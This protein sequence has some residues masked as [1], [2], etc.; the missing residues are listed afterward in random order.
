MFIAGVLAFSLIVPL[1]SYRIS[2]S[3]NRDPGKVA[4]SLSLV[5]WGSLLIGL[6]LAKMQN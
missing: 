3:D 6:L 4:T 5:A 1:L 2:K